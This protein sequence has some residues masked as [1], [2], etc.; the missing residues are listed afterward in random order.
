MSKSG[1]ILLMVGGVLSLLGVFVFCW[2]EDMGDSLSG[3]SLRYIADVFSMIS[4][5]PALVWVA[6]ILILLTFISGLFILLGIKVRA[7]AIIFGLIST[8]LTIC[9]VLYWFDVGGTFIE[10]IINPT[11]IWV[12]T[13][14]SAGFPISLL[15][16][17]IQLG[18]YLSLA[19]GILGLIGGFANKK[20]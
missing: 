5:A 12:T 9:W 18:A 6:V 4:G 2:Y 8:F 11:E 16:G 7:L 1:K 3:Y 10:D 20:D 19:G 17:E 13:S 15:L 14:L